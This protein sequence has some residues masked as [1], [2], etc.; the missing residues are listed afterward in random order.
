MPHFY[1]Q[2]V[3]LIA[4]PFSITDIEFQKISSAR[5]LYC[6]QCSIRHDLHVNSD[7]FLSNNL[8]CN[9]FETKQ[10]KLYL[11]PT[12]GPKNFASFHS[13]IRSLRKNFK[14]LEQLLINLNIQL[15]IKGQMETKIKLKH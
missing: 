1:V 2:N 5:E 8:E 6:K 10:V 11:Y 13:N 4:D 3:Q 15:D 14:S 12:N 7:L 9:Y